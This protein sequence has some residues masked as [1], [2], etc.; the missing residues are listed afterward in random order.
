[1]LGRNMGLLQGLRCTAPLLLAAV[2]GGATACGPPGDR[3]PTLAL[4]EFHQRDAQGVFLNETLVFH[5]SDELD[6]ASVTRGSLRI[7]DPSRHLV[8]GEMEVAGSKVLFH[9]RLP[10]SP[11]LVDGGLRPGRT[12]RV[13]VQGFPFP[14]GLRARDGAPLAETRRFEFVT[15]PRPTDDQQPVFDQPFQDTV[16]FLRL[17]DGNIGPLDPIWLECDE[18]ID[19]RSVLAEGFDLWRIVGG[20]TI[21]HLAVRARLVENLRDRALIELRPRAGPGST[22]GS[23][24]GAGGGLG[25]L[26]PGEYYL[27]L[28]DGRGPRS[29]GGLPVEPNWRVSQTARIQVDGPRVE[30]SRSL[31]LHPSPQPVAGVDGT[32]EWTEDG[33]VRI[34]FP[35]AAGTGVDG[36][37]ELGGES[38]GA[39]VQA[40]RLLLPKRATC[41]LPTQGPVVLRAQGRLEIAGDLRRGGEP[42]EGDLELAAGETLSGLVARA[43][44]ESLAATFL[45]AGGD[46]VVD[47]S[48]Q[49]DGPLV[50]AAG[51]RIRISGSIRASGVLRIG[52][53]GGGFVH[54]APVVP[55]GLQMSLAPDPTEPPGEQRRRV[56]AELRRIL[57]PPEENPLAAPVTYAV[58]S[59]PLRP[60]QGV[61]SWRAPRS[62]GREGAGAWRV[63][64]LGLREVELPGGRGTA[65]EEFGPVDDALLLGDCEALRVLVE[66]SMPADGGSWDPPEVDYVELRWEAPPS[67][68]DPPR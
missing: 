31:G 46:L 32:A 64:F 29:L 61:A 34:R 44:S 14:D 68:A 60:P 22:P 62:A 47:G 13:E 5:F 67:A 6:R 54:P 50:L 28:V 56:E 41:R 23:T 49:V 63:R 18:G 59:A 11:D 3:P 45:V 35:R 16:P 24:P 15:V 2:L 1:M 36:A 30:D 40:T 25:A 27:H 33:R 58:L 9:P 12:Y 10:L 4:L 17:V 21:E 51:G 20:E 26:D 8:A 52:D 65:V 39:D 37:V 48:I 43:Q 38:P 55:P 53:G 19:P 66:L 57:D 7:L 42:G